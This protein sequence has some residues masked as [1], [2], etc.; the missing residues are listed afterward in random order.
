MSLPFVSIGI[1][2][3]NEWPNIGNTLRYL[4]NQDYPKD[5]YEIIVVD[6]NSSDNTI[7]AAKSV[8]EKGSVQYKVVNESIFENKEWGV[9]FWPC[10]WRNLI[11]DLSDDKST[12]I[13]LTDGDCRTATNWLSTLVNAIQ[14]YSIDEKVVW[15]GWP[16][17]VEIQWNIHPKELVLNYYFTSYIMSLWNAAFNGK[18]ID[19]NKPYYMSSIAWY[20]SIYKREVL[21]KYRYDTKLVVTDDIEINYRLVKDW[22]KLIACPEAE[23]YHREEDSVMNFLRNMKRYGLNIWNA[24]LKHKAFI[25]SYVPLSILYFLYVVLFPLGFFLCSLIFG[26]WWIYLLPLIAVFAL[27]IAVFIENY[28]QTKSFYSLYTFVL[29]PSHP[30]MYAY[31]VL[32]NILGLK[33]YFRK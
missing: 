32:I 9:N 24:I 33:K 19:K 23:M 26:F 22:Y 11:I 25:R 15:I 18:G 7:D 20:N 29:V 28:S 21:K 14:K 3:R 27:S 5:L 16:R 31:G 8:L 6:W 12:Y 1:I 10:F 4:L 2:A 30:F 13:A 17:L